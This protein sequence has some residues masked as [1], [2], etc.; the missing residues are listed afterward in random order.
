[1]L[2]LLTLLGGAYA[3]YRRFQGSRP[4]TAQSRP[5]PRPAANRTANTGSKPASSGR[6]TKHDV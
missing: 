2:R 4:S 3:L 6:N 5:A 1:M